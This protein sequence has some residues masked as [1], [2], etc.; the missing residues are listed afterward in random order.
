MSSPVQ[1]PNSGKA[2]K[3]SKDHLTYSST[4]QGQVQHTQFRCDW[5]LA[6]QSDAE[7]VT[8]LGFQ[9]SE[10]KLYDQGSSSKYLGTIERWE[11]ET[12]QESP[13]N[14]YKVQKHEAPEETL[15]DNVGDSRSRKE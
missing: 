9:L 6:T 12:Q 10:T 8:K 11:K 4:K 7:S 1:K 14:A 3:N 13:W 15:E 2:T 5:Y